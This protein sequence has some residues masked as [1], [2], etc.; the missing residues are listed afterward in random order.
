MKRRHK[1]KDNGYLVDEYGRIKNNNVR[2]MSMTTTDIIDMMSM[3][4]LLNM[5]SDSDDGNDEDKVVEDENVV[6]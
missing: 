5:I 1:Q 2:R 3:V 4:E 6:E